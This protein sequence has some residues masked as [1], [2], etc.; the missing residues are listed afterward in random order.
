MRLAECPTCH[1]QKLLAFPKQHQW[2]ACLHCHCSGFLC[3][4][5]ELLVPLLHDMH[6]H[7]RLLAANWR[8]FGHEVPASLLHQIGLCTNH[9]L[10]E[11]L[12]GRLGCAPWPSFPHWGRKLHN[13][14]VG[15]PPKRPTELCLTLPIER[16]PGYLIGWLVLLKG[17]PRMLLP[18]STDLASKALPAQPH[19]LY[20]YLTAN[21]IHPTNYPS[22]CDAMAD[23]MT[24][25][26]PNT[27]LVADLRLTRES[28][29]LVPRL[30]V[31]RPPRPDNPPAAAEQSSA[32]PLE[33][34]G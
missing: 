5:N 27:T 10:M 8:Q 33:P 22:I 19:D 14:P 26:G 17:A 25:P 31:P 12:D 13:A 29:L 4:P 2:Y 7:Q 34:A 30:V 32:D 9:P 3:P 28:S 6:Q 21:S 23:W 18:F 15:R 20:V 1:E 16:M 24:L 11:R